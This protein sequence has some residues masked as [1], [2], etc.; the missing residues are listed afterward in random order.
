MFI[1]RRRCSMTI[2]GTQAGHPRFGANLTAPTGAVVSFS[3]WF[4]ADLPAGREAN[5]LPSPMTKRFEYL[6]PREFQR[7]TT[8]KK[9]RYLAELQ[10]HLSR[11]RQASRAL[12][13][14]VNVNSTL[15]TAPVASA[16]PENL[17]PAP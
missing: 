14:G 17:R 13:A 1:L 6:S 11:L 2:T 8:L 4:S 10:T 16:Q 3:A 7:L 15:P 5:T 9:T 12:S